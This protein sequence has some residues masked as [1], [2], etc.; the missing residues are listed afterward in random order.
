MP[1]LLPGPRPGRPRQPRAASSTRRARGRLRRRCP[2]RTRAPTTGHVE[3]DPDEVVASLRQAIDAA[4]TALPAGSRILAAG[5]ATQRSSMVCWHRRTGAAL[6]PV[7]SWQDRRN[8]AWLER[9]GAA[10]RQDSRADGP[11]PDAPLRGQQDA[12][13]PRQPARRPG[14][15]GRGRPRDGPARQL[16]RSAACW[17]A[18][19]CWPIPPMP[20][21][22][23]CGHWQRRTGRR[24]CWPCSASTPGV[25]PRA[26]HEPLRLRTSSRRRPVPCP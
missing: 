15:A 19:R 10:G 20:P 2:S 3:H 4:C 11:G 13:V 22:R 25:L 9:L 7:I 17:K 23:S 14:C 8:A 5:L 1:N 24:N 18:G 12:L 6:S 26:V 21:A 16:P